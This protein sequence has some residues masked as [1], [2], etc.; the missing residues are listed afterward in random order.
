MTESQYPGIQTK[1]FDLEATYTEGQLSGYRWYDKKGVKP[2]FPFGHGLTYGAF[3]FGP[4]QVTGRVVT[5]TV[6][7]RQGT[8]CETPQ[9]YLSY[10]GAETDPKAPSKVLR[11]FVKTC[12]PST[13]VQ[14]TV[15]DADI[16]N[17]DVEAQAWKLTPGRYSIHVGA[18]SQDIRQT[19]TANFA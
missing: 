10:P 19:T 8:G 6:A 11:H 2:A 18:S 5:F 7:R 13:T 12:K 9:V 3:T 4:V 16:S 15:R 1:D 14:Y 17:W